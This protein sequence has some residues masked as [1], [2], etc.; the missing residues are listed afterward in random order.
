MDGQAAL[1]GPSVCRGSAA[2]C[3]VT[4]LIS[5]RRSFF[6]SGFRAA[7]RWSETDARATQRLKIE[8]DSHRHILLKATWV[9]RTPNSG[10]V[11]SSH[12]GSGG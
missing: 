8:I 3:G 7:D 12:T 6:S 1:L 9:P 5:I 2:G 4:A 11:C 10:V